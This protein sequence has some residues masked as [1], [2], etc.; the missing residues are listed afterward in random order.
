[1][2]NILGCVL[3]NGR[4]GGAPRIACEDGTNIVPGHTPNLP[5]TSPVPY[6]VNISGIPSSGYVPGQNYT[7]KL[8]PY[9][10]A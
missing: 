9:P 10:R 6:S 8:L 4:T 3:V 5:P 1:M 2:S 7:S